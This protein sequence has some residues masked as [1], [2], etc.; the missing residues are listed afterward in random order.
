MP[1]GSN[2]IMIVNMLGNDLFLHKIKNYVVC[3]AGL[4]GQVGMM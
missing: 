1:T 2:I 3:F 4:V